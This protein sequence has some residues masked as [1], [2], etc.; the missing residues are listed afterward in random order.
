MDIQAGFVPFKVS[1]VLWMAQARRKTFCSCFQPTLGRVRGW[2]MPATV[3]TLARHKLR[4]IWWQ[5][6][7]VTVGNLQIKPWVAWHAGPNPVDLVRLLR[8]FVYILFSI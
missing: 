4:S 5:F 6:L 1:I 2:Q 3:S 8:T 7:G